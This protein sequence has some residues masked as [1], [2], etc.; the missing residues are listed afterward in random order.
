MVAVLDSSVNYR[1]VQLSF[2]L[3]KIRYFFCGS[4]AQSC[5]HPVLAC[6]L[7]CG[8]VMHGQLHCVFVPSLISKNIAM[9]WIAN[10]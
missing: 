1:E 9:H 4:K 6:A 7:V 10:P 3:A 8:L 2:G 5:P